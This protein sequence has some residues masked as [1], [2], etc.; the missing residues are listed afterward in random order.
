LTVSDGILADVVTVNCE[1]EM[2]VTAA[3][4]TVEV[5]STTQKGVLVNAV[6]K[7]I[8]H[9]DGL[10]VPSVTCPALSEEPA[11][12]AGVAPQE[13][14][15]GEVARVFKW[16]PRDTLPDP[17]L[18]AIPPPDALKYPAIPEAD[19]AVPETAVDTST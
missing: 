15:E 7:V 16:L 19:E 2:A 13:D 12:T 3:V 17:V 1:L 10:P 11:V 9:P 4:V 18:I 14:A 6:P 8:V 5:V